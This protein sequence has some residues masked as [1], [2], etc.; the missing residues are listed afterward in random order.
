M[1]EKILSE[2]L[3]TMAREANTGAVNEDDLDQKKH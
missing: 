1:N 2:L 3:E